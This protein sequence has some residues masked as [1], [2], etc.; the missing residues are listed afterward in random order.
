MNNS[1]NSLVEGLERLGLI[2]SRIRQ[3]QGSVPQIEIDIILQELRNLYMTCLQ[4]EKDETVVD[5]TDTLELDIAAAAKKAAE[6]KRLAE[7]AA[8][9]KAAEEKR[10]AEE[11][12]AKKAAEEKR[13]A[14]EAAAKKAAEEKRLAEEAAA[15]KAAEEKR[16]AEEAAAKKAAEEKRLAEEAAAKKAA[17]EKRL[18]EEIAAKKAAEEK[19]LAEEAAAKKAAEAAATAAAIAA[20]NLSPKFA[21]E[22]SPAKPEVPVEAQMEKL[23]G[24]P[25]DILFADE[26]A[27]AKTE[28]PREASLFD[29]LSNDRNPEKP[30][31][32]TIGDTLNQKVPNVE[33]RL[34][35][36]VNA[37][38]VSDLREIIGINDKFSFMSDLFHNKMKDYND[39]ILH[40]NALNDREEALA[41]VATVAEEYKWREDSAA[42]VNFYRVFDRKF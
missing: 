27:P 11:A 34:E 13:L 35:S 37:K 14:E 42:V 39:F 26:P 24:N 25:N 2:A 8:A 41:Y 9:K 4:L 18:A 29:F 32:R 30:T 17:E 28:K 19:R 23:S 5:M 21:P 3:N 38:K 10:L 22:T 33:Q 31:V 6:E 20:A 40:L 7:E 15:K 12:A 36:R 16:L 1:S